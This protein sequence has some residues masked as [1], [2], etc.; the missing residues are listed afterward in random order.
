[1]NEHPKWV[2]HAAE[3]ITGE[4]YGDP[5]GERVSTEYGEKTCTGVADIIWQI[6]K[7]E[8]E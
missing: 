3:V 5:E 1:M 7:K 6:F 2:Q 8:G 4:K